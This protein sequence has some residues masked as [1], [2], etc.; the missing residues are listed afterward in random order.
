MTSYVIGIKKND[1][2]LFSKRIVSA[3]G[4]V[5]CYDINLRMGGDHLDWFMDR[6]NVVLLVCP[7]KKILL[8]AKTNRL[9]NN[10]LLSI[11]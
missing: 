10:L 6:G 5:K 2:S 11:L 7:R 8:S 3:Q 9:P 1:Y 4:R